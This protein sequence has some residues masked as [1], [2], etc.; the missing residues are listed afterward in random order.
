[1]KVSL[2]VFKITIKLPTLFVEHAENLS[3][4]SV[5]TSWTW[6]VGFMKIA[7]DVLESVVGD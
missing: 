1:M 4:E 6:D 7:G 2:I 5:S 3:K